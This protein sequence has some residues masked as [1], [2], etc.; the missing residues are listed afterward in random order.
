MVA[1]RKSASAQVEAVGLHNLAKPL[2]R[3]LVP[4]RLGRG[5]YELRSYFGE[6]GALTSAALWLTAWW[7]CLQVS[8]GAAPKRDT[9]AVDNTAALGV[10]AG[11]AAATHPQAQVTSDT[12]RGIMGS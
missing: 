9:I 11:R 4:A 1:T 7:N 10:A 3:L 2:A 5:R 12:S 8:T 6:L